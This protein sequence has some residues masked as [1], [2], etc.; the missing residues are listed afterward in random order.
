MGLEVVPC[1][2]LEMKF[3]GGESAEHL[4]Q[5]VTQAE[6]GEN[7]EWRVDPGAGDAGNLVKSEDKRGAN[8]QQRMKCEKRGETD[9]HPHGETS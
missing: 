6:D 1:N 5:F 3:Q 9:E 8:G 4:S 2:A 7:G